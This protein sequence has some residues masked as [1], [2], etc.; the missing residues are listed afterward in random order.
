MS[1]LVKNLAS[2]FYFLMKKTILLFVFT[3]LFATTAIANGSITQGNYRWRNDDGNMENA[4]AKADENVNSTVLKETNVRLR[5]GIGNYDVGDGEE[6]LGLYYS[7]DS[8][9][10]THITNDTNNH[11]QLSLSSY[12]D[13]SDTINDLLANGSLSHG[14]GFT[15]ESTVS[16]SFTLYEN[17]SAEFE[18]CIKATSNADLDSTYLFAVIEDGGG[19][20]YNTLPKL[21]MVS[22]SLNVSP[23]SKVVP[24]SPGITTSFSITSNT[25]WTISDDAAW[26]ITSLNSGSGDDSF[27]ASY[28][29]NTLPTSR[30][31]TITVEASGVPDVEVTVTQSGSSVPFHTIVHNV[32]ISNGQTE[33]YEATST[34][35]VAGSGTTVDILSGGQATFIAGQNIFWHAGF[36]AHSG[37]NCHGY[38]TESG[39][40]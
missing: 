16:K 38:I 36:Y 19:Y 3:S 30:M 29:E 34:I 26:L 14:G 11:F 1:M 40:Y 33:C 13:E 7:T 12:F 6:D 28:T 5:V 21:T 35:I 23:P 25:N 8:T 4:T 27:T 31:A 18:Y 37:S 22:P 39:D 10:W 32:T 2:I 15:I 9:I 20:G 17:T 24:S